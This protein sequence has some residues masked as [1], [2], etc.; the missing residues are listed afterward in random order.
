M[1]S[2]RVLTAILF[3]GLLCISECSFAMGKKTRSSSLRSDG[4]SSVNSQRQSNLSTETEI[5]FE[6]GVNFDQELASLNPDVSEG[7]QELKVT[8]NQTGNTVA[9][10]KD[11]PSVSDNEAF[12]ATTTA[13]EP[14]TLTLMGLG[15][16]GLILRRHKK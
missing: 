14:T 1:K 12:P 10:L 2:Y 3:L 8:S 4:W 13:P 16:A 15:M 5:G 6:D 7:Q 9:V 11:A